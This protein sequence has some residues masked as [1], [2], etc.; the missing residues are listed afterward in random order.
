[1]REKP[2]LDVAALPTYGFGPRMTTWWGTLAFC[3]LEGTGFVLATAAYLYLAWLNPTWPLSAPPPGLLWSSLLTLLLLASVIPN[4]L[5]GESAKKEDLPRVRVLLLVMSAIGLA[6]LVLRAYEFGT[7]YVSW[8]QNAYGSL[9]WMILALHTAHLA[10]DVVDTLV[11][12]TLMFT[13]HA[14]GKRFSDVEDN[15]FYWNFV[16]ASWL[17][18]YGLLYWLPRW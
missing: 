15:A 9:L 2:V 3:V 13:R 12:T 4:H 6:S 8:D 11:M 5:A 10:T 17:P 7:L 14:H 1:V 16:V 18:L